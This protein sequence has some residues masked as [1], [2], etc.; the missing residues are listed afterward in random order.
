MLNA[1]GP[2]SGDSSDRKTKFWSRIQSEISEAQ[3]NDVSIIL[4]MDGNLHAGSDIIENDPN[5]INSNGKLFEELLKNNPNLFLVN[6]SDKCEGDITRQRVKG[7]KTETAILDFVLVPLHL[8]N[9]LYTGFE[10]MMCAMCVARDAYLS[11][12]PDI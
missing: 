10:L 5:P 3:D 7:K 11:R 6:G 9:V 12:E 4:Q 1:Y 2:Q 8:D